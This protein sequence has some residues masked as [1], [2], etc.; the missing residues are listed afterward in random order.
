MVNETI[1]EIALALGMSPTIVAMM[2]AFISGS[3]LALAGERFAIS[4][5]AFKPPTPDRAQE[6]AY[7]LGAASLIP[8]AVFIGVGFQTLG[9]VGGAVGLFF[10]LQYLRGD[11]PFGANE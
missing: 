3:L 11:V 2:L 8:L 10:G 1:V 5:K 7:V 6:T 9:I 4:R